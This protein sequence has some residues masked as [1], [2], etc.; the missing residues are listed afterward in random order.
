MGFLS[1]L[2]GRKSNPKV[3]D[4]K[5]EDHHSIKSWA[6]EYKVITPETEEAIYCML[7]AYYGSLKLSGRLAEVV[8]QDASNTI[9]KYAKAVGIKNELNGDWNNIENAIVKNRP[10][11]TLHLFQTGQIIIALAFPGNPP[12][13]EEIDS[14]EVGMKTLGISQATKILKQ[15]RES[16][17]RLP[18]D[19]NV[20][21]AAVWNALSDTIDVL[22]RRRGG[23]SEKMGKMT[24]GDLMDTS[25]E[26][27]SHLKPSEEYSKPE[28]NCVLLGYWSA[29]FLNIANTVSGDSVIIVKLLSTAAEQMMPYVKKLN[30]SLDAITHGYNG[31]KQE[32][33]KS[34]T[35]KAASSYRIGFLLANASCPMPRFRTQKR[36]DDFLTEV[37]NIKLSHLSELEN[38]DKAIISENNEVIAT[39]GAET[40]YVLAN[41]LQAIE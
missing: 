34:H 21:S 31:I 3:S 37:K 35:P 18:S 7:G 4:N 22:N 26:K 8:L 1:R 25:L 33:E 6:A 12:S 14:L 16:S 5:M 38:L 30:L 40:L 23:S 13:E 10:E 9:F 36:Y 11:S 32:I 41:A 29:P 28:P 2:F 39:A 20:Q 15:V 19:A 27:Y 24:M 17:Q